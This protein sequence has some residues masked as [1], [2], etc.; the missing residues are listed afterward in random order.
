MGQNFSKMFNIAFQEGETTAGNMS[1]A[2]QNSWG[3]ST[4]T[5]GAVVMVHGDD[6]GLVLPPRVAAVQVIV[7]PV[8]ITSKIKEEQ[9]QAFFEKIKDITTE[10]VEGK[11]R[12]ELDDRDN[13]TAGWKFSHWEQKGVPIRMEVGPRDLAEDKVSIVLRWNGEKSSIPIKD[14]VCGV[15]E[16]LDEIHFGMY[17]R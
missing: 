1:F 8:G 10:L 6:Q 3:L 15:R 16:H 5:L 11:I 12:A 9:K 17:E 14:L 13:I 4:R 2:Y 7:I